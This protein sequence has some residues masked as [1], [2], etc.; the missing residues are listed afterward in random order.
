MLVAGLP[1]AR[2][3]V[4]QQRLMFTLNPGELSL[5]L[6]HCRPGT[7]ARSLEFALSLLLRGQC[8][9]SFGQP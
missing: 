6:R 2:L 7:V 9:A 1:R 5:G 4:A 3:T 8:R